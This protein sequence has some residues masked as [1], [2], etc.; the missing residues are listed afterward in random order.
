MAVTLAHW[1]LADYHNMIKAGLFEGRH[2]ELLNGY[3]A[4]QF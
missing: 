1:T 3:F 2:I 4:Q